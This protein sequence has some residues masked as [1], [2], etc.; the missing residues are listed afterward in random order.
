[1]TNPGAFPGNRDFDSSRIS[2]LNTRR[3]IVEALV[4]LSVSNTFLFDRAV[5]AGEEMRPMEHG[6][7]FMIKLCSDRAAYEA[8][9]KKRFKVD[10][11]SLRLSLE[12]SGDYE[13]AVCTPQLIVVKRRDATEVTVVD[14]GRMI[15]RNAADQDAAKRIAETIL[16][17]R[18]IKN[19]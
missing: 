19:Y 4:L 5:L 11:T 13:I 15:I 2:L 16:A 7:A 18:A 9:P 12:C 8:V 6:A 3:E 10:I 1:M 17:N 14:D